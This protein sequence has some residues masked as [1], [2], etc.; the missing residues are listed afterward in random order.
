MNRFLKDSSKMRA[1]EAKL[2]EEV[3]TVITEMGAKNSWLIEA[4]KRKAE[5]NKPMSFQKNGR[6]DWE[7][8]VCKL[9]AVAT[10]TEHVRQNP[11]NLPPMHVSPHLC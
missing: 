1:S 9:Q 2:P 10:K 3:R 4:S 7:T 11:L 6:L 8:N 5:V